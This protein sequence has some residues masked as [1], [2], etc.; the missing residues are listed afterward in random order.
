[1]VTRE[2]ELRGAFRFDTEFDAAIAHLAG[3]LDVRGVVSHRLPLGRAH[4]A[5]DLAGDRRQAA[6]VLLDL[7]EP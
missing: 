7:R 6:K 5:F 2:I 1:M 3:G 4:E